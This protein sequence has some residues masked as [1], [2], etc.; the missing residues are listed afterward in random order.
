MTEE[1]PLP[2][3]N[4]TAVVRVGDTVRREAGPWTPAVHALLRTLRAAGIEAVPEP[5]GFDDRGREVLSFLPGEVG[6]YPLPDWLWDPTILDDAGALLRRVHD[7]SV[8]LVVQD[9]AWRS[10]RHDP[11]EVICHND[12][13]PYN[14]TFSGGR[15]TGLFDFDMAAPGP[16]LRDL[17]YLAYR[18]APLA[19]D[20]GAEFTTEQQSG[21]I[22]RLVSAYGM[23]FS[24]FEVLTAVADRL[25]ELAEYTDGRYRETGNPEFAEHAAMYRRD[26]RRAERL[27]IEAT[28][29][30]GG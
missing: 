17:S 29:A 21:R 19:E 30:V 24:R 26:A 22:D 10:P 2:G 4:S 16:R 14:M 23:P 3:G 6:A 13:A 1:Q 15:L 18:L 8:P 7:A 28:G 25:R 20:A 11:A 9:L 12:A 27:S 5:I